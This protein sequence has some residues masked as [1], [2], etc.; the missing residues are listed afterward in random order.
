MDTDDRGENRPLRGELATA[1]EVIDILALLAVPVTL[2]SVFYLS[3]ETRR[4]LTFSYTEPTV[5]TAFTAPYVHLEAGHLLANVGGYLLVVPLV[6]VLASLAGY[7]RLF[8]ITFVTFA[9]VLPPILSYLNLAIAR[10]GMT[11]GFSGVLMAFIGVLP[12]TTAAHAAVYLRTERP[13]NVASVL[14][15]LW[16]AFA[17]VL[18][19]RS[20]LTYGIALASVLTATLYLAS[21]P[22]VDFRR[23]IRCALAQGSH[24]GLATLSVG[25]FFFMSLV[26]FPPTVG[27]GRTVVNVYVHLLGCTIGF[28]STYVLLQV[29]RSVWPVLDAG[30]HR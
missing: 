29:D 18:S 10:P 24:F 3:L 11:V 2:C 12:L 5:A 28:I 4:E 27:G 23:W 9:L 19:L 20:P 16:L 25:V 1:F 7:R 21:R 8:Y 6:F 30:R 22:A 14:F 17:A 26:A 15:F 13:L